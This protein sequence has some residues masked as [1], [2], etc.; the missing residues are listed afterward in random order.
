M[1]MNPHSGGGKVS[2]FQLAERAERLGARVSMIGDSRDAGS[3]ARH[4]V[5][6]GAEVLGVAGG[7]GTVSAVAT[8]AA[9]AD[10]PLLVIPAGTRNHFA[11]DL[12]LNTRNP[13]RALE[14]LLD[15]QPTHIDL[16]VIDSHV[17]VNNVSFGFYAEALL[18]PG[19]REAKARSLATVAP[20]YLEGQQWVNASIDAPEGTIE[21]PQVVLVSNNPYQL[22]IPRYH[23]RRLSLTAGLLGVVVLKRPTGPPPPDLLSRLRRDL[24]KHGGSGHY[25]GLSTWSAAQVTLQGACAH[26]PAG[27]DGEPVT[28]HLPA[29]CQVHPGGLRVLLPR[30]RPG[31]AAEEHRRA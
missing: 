2:R 7:D 20:G 26:L 24:R 29:T 3:L 16:G 22:A 21:H 19:Y 8:V 17:F 1:L 18:E 23:G 4:A 14:V 6:A 30:R 13:A 9:A 15:G 5:E 11:R 10:V 25:A 12:G 31:I 28:L 27:I